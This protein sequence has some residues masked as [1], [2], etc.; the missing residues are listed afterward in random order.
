MPN[1]ITQFKVPSYGDMTTM[2]SRRVWATSAVAAILAL[3]LQDGTARAADLPPTVVAPAPSALSGPLATFVAPLA[4]KG[5]TFHATVL[6]F[7]G[8]NPSIGLQRGR[9]SN[10]GYFI[11]GVDVDL[12]KLWGL[13]GTSIHFENIFFG[14]VANL[15]AA[16]QI[17]DAQI[18]YPPPYTPELARLSRAT[19]E[20]KLL[21]GKLDIEAGITHPGYY[22]ASFNCGTYNACFQ[23]ILY[24]DAGYTSY[25]FGVPGGNMTY[26]ITPK[27]YVQAGAF[28]H[29]PN[30]NKFSGYDFYR[31]QYDGVLAMGEIGSNTT[32]ANDPYP[33]KVA[34]TGYFDSAIHTS[35]TAATAAGFNQTRTGT[36]GLVLQGQKVVWRRD[37]GADP[38]DKAPTAIRIYGSFG[39]SL[40]TTTAIQAD[41]W[42]GA[43]LTAPFQSRPLDYY[44]VKVYW[45][46]MNEGYSQ[47]SSAFVPGS[48]YKRDSY[49]FEASSHLALPLGAAFE[50]VVD[51]TVNP[52]NYWN[53]T[54]T[55][56]VHDGVYLGGTL[57]VPLGVILGLSAPT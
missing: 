32:Y 7:F 37:G 13:P 19:V 1:S 22:F 39:T 41:S 36:S 28:A 57:A 12:A 34:L 9:G 3:G 30:A 5:I 29:Q 46:R 4:E 15:N 56:K 48:P 10:S 31:E 18:G 47:Y 2:R 53:P 44:G 14:G 16:S 38:T 26:A 51:Y 54:S 21:D 17:G 50:P 49:T 8:D 33:Y 23:D 27:V 24:I 11:E 52:N 6:D 25:A 35:F 42:L 55:K 40:D 45:E 20:Q 43:T